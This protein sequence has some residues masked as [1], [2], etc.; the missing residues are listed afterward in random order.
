MSWLAVA[1][2]ASQHHLIII[3]LELFEFRRDAR[4]P[5]EKSLSLEGISFSSKGDKH[6]IWYRKLVDLV[7]LVWRALPYFMGEPDYKATIS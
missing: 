3:W 5:V 1:I 2:V 4:C 6:E 7:R